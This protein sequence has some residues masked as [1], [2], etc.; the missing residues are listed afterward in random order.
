MTLARRIIAINQAFW[1]A[2]ALLYKLE[3]YERE[4]AQA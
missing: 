4:V 1:L 2:S 3:G